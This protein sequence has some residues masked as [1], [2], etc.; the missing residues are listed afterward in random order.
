MRAL[1]GVDYLIEL[2]KKTRA[3]LRRH[4]RRTAGDGAH[5]PQVA[6]Q[7][8]HRQR[9]ADVVFGQ[10]IALRAEDAS[11]LRQAARGEWNI[12][13][14]NDVARTGLVGDPV[15]NLAECSLDD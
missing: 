7:I 8:P 12:S 4:R 5:L 2:G 15:V 6:H 3:V 13:S 11:A 10:R 1:D 9:L 14:N